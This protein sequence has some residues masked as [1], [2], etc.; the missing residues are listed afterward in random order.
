MGGLVFE[1][2][3]IIPSQCVLGEGPVWDARLGCL[4][5]TDIQSAQ[6][7]CWHHA[8]ARLVRHGLP[9][10]L[11]SFALTPD[12][13]TL[14]CAFASGFAHYGP[15]TGAI[16]WL[17]RTE[18]DY[19][20]I[21]MNDGRADRAGRF[22]VGSM[23]EDAKLAPAHRGALYRLDASDGRPAATLFDGIRISNS[24]CFSPDGGQMYF[25]D[26]P[27]QEIVRFDCDAADGGLS[28][29]RHFARL[30]GDAFPDGSDIDAAGGV[31]NAEWGSGRVTGYAPDGGVV[32]QIQLPVSQATCMAFG[33]AAFDLMFVTTA[34]EGLSPERRTAEPHAGDVF[35][36][37][38][39][40][41]GLPAP[42]CA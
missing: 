23:V 41:S 14:L 32:A 26:T 10:R 29:R 5:F 38:C 21:R 13:A 39:N 22:W 17:H 12:P 42:I 1:L 16:D 6:L 15:A 34:S 36:Y 28:N 4:W 25:A 33:G 20:G 8:E 19:R 40:F 27:S 2:V 37:Q 30:S 11:G 31:W 7:L 9:E 24:I 18:P 35:V 3:A